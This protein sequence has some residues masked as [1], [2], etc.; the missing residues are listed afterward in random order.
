MKKL[1]TAF[2]VLRFLILSLLANILFFS[3]ISF[4]G[5]IQLVGYE[6]ST[7]PTN[8]I[9]L[10]EEPIIWDHCPSWNLPEGWLMIPENVTPQEYNLTLYKQSD[11]TTPLDS[12]YIST[13]LRANPSSDGPQESYFNF[14][15]WDELKSFGDWQIN[16]SYRW[17]NFGVSS[18]EIPC[19]W[20]NW[21]ELSPIQFEYLSHCPEPATLLLFVSGSVGLF[22]LGRKRKKMA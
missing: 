9:K 11:I 12:I 5:E 17:Y 14:N 21:E 2:V 7:T 8:V 13:S 4:A 15:N 3:G 10:I 16:V 22:S 1:F 20:T 19:G 18:Q 6:N